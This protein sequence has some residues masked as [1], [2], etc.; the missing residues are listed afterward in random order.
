MNDE[1]LRL[2]FQRGDFLSGEEISESLGISRAAVWKRIHRL[3]EQGYEIEAV[4]NRG[5]KLS[6]DPQ[7]LVYGMTLEDRFAQLDSRIWHRLAFFETLDSS[8]LEGKRLLAADPEAAGTVIVC[9]EQT[10]GRGRRG[11]SWV[12]PPGAGIWTSLILKPQ[13]PPQAASMLTLVAGMAVHRAIGN[14]FDLQP[15]IKWPNDI[16]LRNRK[17]CGI[18]TEMSVEDMEM[19]GVVIGI[20]INVTNQAFPEELSEIATSVSLELDRAADA[21]ID[22]AELLCRLLRDFEYYYTRFMQ[23]QDLSLL[24]DEYNA[25]CINCGRIVNVI[26]PDQVYQARAIGI[27]AQG[28]L[29]IRLADGTEKA[30]SSGEVTI[31]GVMGYG[32]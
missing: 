12:S 31:R 9:E 16:L 14:G 15:Q 22:R 30:V 1:I 8:N 4:P 2:L 26:A 3:Q 10:A 11:R 20:G 24:M 13:I 21:L 32:E 17:V 29:R 27:D 25:C 23:T 19:T 7:G 18:L 6:G 5:Y 28:R